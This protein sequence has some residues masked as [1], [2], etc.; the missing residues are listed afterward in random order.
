RVPLLSRPTVSSDSPRGE[1]TCGK[2]TVQ[3]GEG[4]LILAPAMGASLDELEHRLSR[5]GQGRLRDT[6][7]DTDAGHTQLAEPRDGGRAGHGHDV[8]R[9]FDGADQ[10]GNRRSVDDPR[11]EDTIRSRRPVAAG[12]PHPPT[13]AAPRRR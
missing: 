11:D 9:S 3:I 13:P 8:E 12:A 10:G 5:R 1:C 4:N 6:R 7:T 2:E